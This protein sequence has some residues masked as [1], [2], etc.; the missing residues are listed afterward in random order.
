[1]TVVERIIALAEGGDSAELRA[2]LE[3][4]R[5]MLGQMRAILD[6]QLRFRERTAVVREQEPRIRGAFPRI[7]GALEKMR[8]A[9]RSA[10]GR[11]LGSAFATL[12]EALDALRREEESWPTYSRSPYM[13]VLMRIAKGVSRG[14]IGPEALAQGLQEMLGQHRRFTANLDR[15]G[16][17][18]RDAER[19]EARRIELFTHLRT[20]EVALS[21]ALEGLGAGDRAA[22]LRRVERACTA[23]DALAAIQEELQ[24]AE[25]AALYRPCLRC[26]ATNARAARSCAK[27]GAVLPRLPF[28]DGPAVDLTI[29]EGGVR[30]R[31]H[32][33]TEL[34]AALEDAVVKAREGRSTAGGLGRVLDDMEQRLARAR[35]DF[36]ALTPAEGI[37]PEQREKIADAMR[38]GF[39]EFEQGLRALRAWTVDGNV[40]HLDHGLEAALSG[41]DRLAELGA[42][43]RGQER[44]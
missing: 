33:R 4:A 19:Y 21:T 8:G 6:G 17:G 36:E 32:V 10:A 25:E 14:T 31:G 12:M 28:D 34:T 16:R 37:D 15:I 23:A 9:D 40:A 39:S 11:E 38:T 13:N 44:Q 7:A 20:I 24:Q 42:A 26:A 3:E 2:A 29:A 18:G 22:V 43:V 5:M 35:R 30:G 27:C 1:M 41:A